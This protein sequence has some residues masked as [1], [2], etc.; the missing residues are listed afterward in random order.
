MGYARNSP[1]GVRKNYG[2]TEIIITSN[3]GTE[4]KLN[5]AGIDKAVVECDGE[6][7]SSKS[8]MRDKIVIE[9]TQGK[10]YK[11]CNLPKIV[12]IDSP[13]NLQIDRE[14]LEIRWDYKDENAVFNI[15]RVCESAPT[16]DLIACNVKGK[17]YKDKLNFADYQ[18]VRYK[19]TAVVNGYESEGV[20][21]T[22]NHATQLEIDRYKNSVY[23][24][25]PVPNPK[26][27]NQLKIP[28]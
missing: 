25:M 15:F 1:N 12:K 5:Y 28:E 27:S 3:K 11:I 18:V 17:S 24:K 21:G 23:F 8:K 9:T 10:K 7:I 14:T 4:L 20:C 13:T 6:I 22:I 19:I 26:K 16:Y 2:A